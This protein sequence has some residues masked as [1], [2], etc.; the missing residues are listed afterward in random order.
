MSLENSTVLYQVFYN[1]KTPSVTLKTTMR[2]M[3]FA[4]TP[5]HNNSYFQ[6][7]RLCSL[8]KLR[9]KCLSLK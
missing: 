4:C 3:F 9:E 7:S 1:F 5:N 8:T 2:V 6:D